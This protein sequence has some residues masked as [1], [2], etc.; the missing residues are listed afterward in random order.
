MESLN[1]TCCPS[2][3][4]SSLFCVNCVTGLSTAVEDIRILP[5]NKP[6]VGAVMVSDRALR[7]N[8]RLGV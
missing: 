5:Q 6:D 1:Y 7:R 4:I 2:T 3:F 8:H